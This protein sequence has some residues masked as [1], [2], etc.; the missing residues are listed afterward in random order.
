MNGS[1]K[2][3]RAQMKRSIKL[4]PIIMCFTLVLSVCIIFLLGVLISADSGGEQNVRIAIGLV[5]DVEETYMGIGISAIQQF[6]TSRFYVDFL[7]LEEEEAKDMLRSG[8][9]TG[10]VLVPDGFVTSVMYGDNMHMSFVMGNNPSALGPVLVREVLDLVENLVIETQN[11]VFALSNL[12]DDYD[13]GRSEV[14]SAEEELNIRYFDAIFTRA[15]TAELNLLGKGKG[16]G[17]A[18]YYFG[19]FVL[20]LMLLWGI[21]CVPLMTKRD[22]ALSRLLYTSGRGCF[23]QVIGEYIPFL[24]IIVINTVMLMGI[25]SVMIDSS[26][27]VNGLELFLNGENIVLSVLRIIPCML[28]ISAMQFFLYELASGVITSVLIQLLSTVVLAYISGFLYPSDSLPDIVQSIAG[29]TP[30]GMSFDYMSMLFVDDPG[31][32]EVMPLIFVFLLCICGAV[33]VRR[34]KIKG[35]AS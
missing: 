15:D 23:G 14:R 35:V 25:S 34:I 11:G 10:Y 27:A 18:E 3:L 13:L 16:L 5:G 21:I 29:I 20:L 22:M 31:P 26:E 6:D 19:A 28:V 33:L 4:W 24:A 9:L 12:A 1:L 8:K 7:T 30:T 32:A 2:Y 17:F